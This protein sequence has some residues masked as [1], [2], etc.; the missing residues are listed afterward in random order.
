MAIAVVFVLLAV[1]MAN[2]VWEK[3]PHEVFAM[4]LIG[5]LVASR[6]LTPEQAFQGFGNSSIVM[7]GAVM[8]LTGAVI[9]N[10]AAETIGRRIASVAGKSER[11][12][13]TL[14]YLAVNSVSAFIN[15]VA[16][17]AMFIP[18]AE[19]VAHRFGVNRGK[20]L[21]PVAFASMTGGMCTLIGTSTNVAVS[22]AMP[23][24]GLAPM[25]L[26]ELT[27]I[28]VPIAIV[29][30]AYLLFVAPKLLAL[31]AEGAPIDVFGIRGFLFEVFVHPRAQLDGLSLA[32]SGLD[33]LGVTV[34]AIVR[35]AERIEAPDAREPIRA[36]DL[37]LVEGETGAIP[38]VAGVKGLEVKSLASPQTVGLTSDKVRMVEAT[39]S[40]NSPFI[41]R[42]L[43]QLN[44]RHRFD[45]SVL[46]IHRRGDPVIEKVGHVELRAGDVLLIYGREAMLAGL[47]R[48]STMLLIEDAPTPRSDPARAAL[49]AAIFVGAILVSAVGWLDAPVA[50]LA[51][52][53]LVLLTRCISVD[54]AADYVSFRFLMLLAGMITL[55]I[56]M[57]KS[58]AAAA[59]AQAIVSLV[60]SKQPIVLLAVFFLVTVLLTQ[61]LNNAAAALIVLPIAVQAAS[62]LHVD[63][64]SYAMGVTIA[65]SCSFLTPF[66]PACLLVYSTGRYRF[67]DFVRVGGFLTLICLAL[68][69][70]VIPVLWPLKP[71]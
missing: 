50:F 35:G 28:G 46:A 63:A 25:R 3:I 16:A 43:K 22:G 7:I 62:L 29:G 68:S 24:Y 66:E 69:L 20:Y 57:E 11:R 15:N 45:L 1:A 10:G 61:P 34:L 39:V 5:A 19:G 42:T 47:V 49:A 54:E 30:T 27:P 55:G 8:V 71:L 18:V 21:I 13:S 67:G 58:G 64:R 26:F 60:P 52:A 44:F 31:P 40:Y 53:G 32:E 36:G 17:T 14:L 33:K 6:V 51:G 37:L 4:L 70:W 23:H 41:G 9:H 56:A 12:A 65:A 2:F 48:A 38:R 59:I